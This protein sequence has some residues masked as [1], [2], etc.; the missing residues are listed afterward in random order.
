MASLIY[1]LLSYV[2][3]GL[4]LPL[5]WLRSRLRIGLGRR[6]GWYPLRGH[7]DVWPVRVRGGRPRI[8]FHG[9]SA[10]DVRAL[11][12]IVRRVR[13]ELPE[14]TLVVSAVTDSG[15]KLAETEL[16]GD[17]DG[18]TAAP[19]DL[20]GATRRTVRAI[21]ADVL[22]LE[23]A[24]LWPNL[25]AAA[26]AL[27][28]RMILV[29]GRL[30]PDRMAGYR[31]LTW[32]AGPVVTRLDRL[33]MRTAD[34]AAR[35]AQ[36]GAP[37][38]RV[39]VTG[40]TKLDDRPAL[41]GKALS[42]TLQSGRWWVAGST[43]A[44]DEEAVLTAFSAL[45]QADAESRLLLAPRYPERAQSVLALAR[46][47][48]WTAVRSSLQADSSDN[49]ADVVVVDTMGR[50]RSA[51]GAARVAF[52]GGTFGRR[53]GHNILEPAGHGV[54]VLAGPDLESNPDATALLRGQG[55]IQVADAP[56]LSQVLVDVWTND[57]LRQSLSQRAQAAVVNASTGA[58]SAAD[59]DAAVV[60]E[61]AR[62]ALS[63]TSAVARIEA[64]T[65]APDR[66]D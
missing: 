44:E 4:G 1:R 37:T 22:V 66:P 14:A 27:G 56:T 10:G 49:D 47:H 64:G 39:E 43:H 24:E 65:L 40:S 62:N 28:T 17:L 60:I 52:V 50:L 57:D 2:V 29:N 35:A 21:A 36:L 3:F 53:G 8:W 33:L 48:G 54:V 12:P 42:P 58:Q 55:L 46:R 41:A 34:D 61:L 15:L 11:G 38:D 25:L 59:R 31:W 5:W 45:R 32:L 26:D 9:A 30:H 18:V 23:A 16:G 7:N 19:L 6:L 13:A 63:D 20:P 51:Y